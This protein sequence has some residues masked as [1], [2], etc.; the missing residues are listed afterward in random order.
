MK[1]KLYIVSLIWTKQGDGHINA[2]NSLHS[3]V[4]AMNKEEALGIAI[5]IG[6]KMAGEGYQ[7][8]QNVIQELT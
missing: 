8:L 5:P 6:Q 4:S 3:K 7:L 1:K 2:Y